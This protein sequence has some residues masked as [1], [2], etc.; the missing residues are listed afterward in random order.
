MP[1][2]P[3]S[4][5][6]DGASQEDGRDLQDGPG[7]QETPPSPP[8]T[9]QTQSGD[10]LRLAANRWIA[11]ALKGLA[12]SPALVPLLVLVA[13]LGLRAQ[14]V[15]PLESGRMM[16]LDLYQQ[17][18]PRQAKTRSVAIVDIDEASLAARG[19][20]PWPRTQVA[21]MIERLV[22]AGAVAIAFDVVFA[23]PDRLSPALFAQSAWRLPPALRRDLRA[24]P[25]NDAVLA[26]VLA[27][28]PVV[29]GMATEVGLP[30]DV[31][32]AP[33][34]PVSMAAV[35]GD[36]RPWLFAFPGLLRN[37]PVLEAAAAGIGLFSL[38]P[39][40]DGIV[41]R[42]P[43]AMRV[44]EAVY[45]ALAIELLRQVAGAGHFALHADAPGGGISQAQVGPLAIP[46]DRHG[47]VWLHAAPHDPGLF[48]SAHAV[49]DGS[50][51]PARVRDKIVLV[52][53][54]ASGLRDLRMTALR[55]V[56]PGPE[57]HAQL[58]DAILSQDFLVRPAL[59][60]ALEL[61]AT[62]LLG[63][64]MIWLMPRLGARAGLGLFL[65]LALLIAGG[66]FLAF[67]QRSQFYDAGFPLA[68]LGLLG[69]LLVYANYTRS[70]RQKRHI[71]TAFGQY[72]SPALVQELTD[73]PNRLHL[74]GETRELTFLFTDIAGFTSFTEKV[75]P[76]VLVSA[77]NGYLDGTCQIVIDHGGTI[78]K[79]V[80][81]AIHAIF[82]APLPQ[83]DHAPRA[84]RCALALDAFTRAFHADMQAQGLDFG[85]TRIGVNSGPAVIGNF[86]GSSRFDYTAHGDAINTAA[87]MEA[88]NKNLGTRI[89]ISEST[90]L[91]CDGVRFRPVGQL[92]L[93]GKSEGLLAYEPI[94]DGETTARFLEE[95]LQAYDLLDRNSD[96][97][98]PAF[99][100]LETKYPHDPI[101]KIYA[102]RLSEGIAGPEL[103]LGEA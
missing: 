46:T 9:A 93:K 26:R 13:L 40:S 54:S 32:R 1:E 89:C 57:I 47:R 84:V 12:G 11:G 73:H 29:L 86:G 20:W 62:A 72:L 21:E 16:L 102:R 88:A 59:A 51:D 97:A 22:A 92:H 7:P 48:L 78:D 81:D 95:Y 10:R 61:L 23:E 101:V 30:A 35:N 90:V 17:A 3:E 70:E 44:G 56:V 42:V 82:G 34:V 39:E 79:I 45:P 83:P 58:L 65:G 36:P 33:L 8:T 69:G 64:A 67:T 25:S 6:Q 91:Q 24:Q 87:R 75:A 15:P 53:T 38:T 4:D 2:R 18:Q 5:P 80:G 37:I 66:S 52:G 100:R 63:L 28:H 14:D 50:F 85:A 98:A 94:D 60:T 74:G 103:R 41:R 31:S 43:T 27:R 99:K 49:L 55:E 19:Q 77:L 76:E 96:Q 68:A 71:R